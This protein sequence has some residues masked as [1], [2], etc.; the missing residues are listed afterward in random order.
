MHYQLLALLSFKLSLLESTK[1]AIFAVFWKIWPFF[2]NIW[3]N[4]I[5]KMICHYVVTVSTNQLNQ[6][7]QCCKIQYKNFC[8]FFTAIGIT[9]M[10]RNNLSKCKYTKAITT[11]KHCFIIKD[12]HLQNN[13][14]TLI[15]HRILNFYRQIHNH[16]HE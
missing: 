3:K 2:F 5:T 1:C 16:V 15:I 8:W 6:K 10:R 11:K 4:C 7:L 9:C 13:K 14:Q 12:L